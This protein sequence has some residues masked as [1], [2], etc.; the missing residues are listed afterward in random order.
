MSLQPGSTQS[1]LKGLDKEGDFKGQSLT[2]LTH[3]NHQF[4][5]NCLGLATFTP[6]PT[7]T[8]N[9]TAPNGLVA[10]PTPLTSEA[11]LSPPGP[12]NPTAVLPQRVVKKIL[13][14]EFVEMAELTTD[15][16]Q[17]DLSSEPP[18]L[19]HRPTRR[20]P[21]TD[22]SVW[23][24]CYFRMAAII[25]TRFPEKAPELWAYQATILRAAQNY[26]GTAWVAY[27]C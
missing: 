20:A 25:V 21:V 7:F 24:E 27:D 19:P 18:N 10:K 12:Y 4:R 17:D 11:S 9:L 14:L 16:W 23:L 3:F 8:L 13:D 22:I 15:A 5:L 1:S 2:Q 6:L 26:E